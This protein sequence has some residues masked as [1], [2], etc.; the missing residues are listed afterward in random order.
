[1]SVS[2]KPSGSFAQ[3]AGHWA[4]GHHIIRDLDWEKPEKNEDEPM[5]NTHWLLFLDNHDLAALRAAS[6]T[7]LENQPLASTDVSIYSA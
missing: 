1:M 7:H 3:P 6:K 2:T 5:N 4:G